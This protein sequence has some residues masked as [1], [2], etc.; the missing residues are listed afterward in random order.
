MTPNCRTCNGQIFFGTADVTECYKCRAVTQ[1]RSRTGGSTPLAPHATL[2]PAQTPS[3]LAKASPHAPSVAGPLEVRRNLFPESASPRL[4]Q[5]GPS[6]PAAPVLFPESASPTP[7][8]HV[9][10]ADPGSESEEEPEAREVV[11]I[12]RATP[13][14]STSAG[15]SPFGGGGPAPRPT[16][17]PTTS[18]FG[19]GSE[20][21]VEARQP[22]ASPFGGGSDLATE[23]RRPAGSHFAPSSAFSGAAVA[24]RH[25]SSMRGISS[26]AGEE[27]PNGEVEPLE[28]A[29]AAGE[30]PEKEAIPDAALE[31]AVPEGADGQEPTVPEGAADV[32]GEGDD[33]SPDSAT[34]DATIAEVIDV[35]IGEALDRRLPHTISVSVGGE[36]SVKHGGKV[37]V[38]HEGGHPPEA[39]PSISEPQVVEAATQLWPEPPT[40]ETP[41]EEA[42]P[43]LWPEPETYD[44]ESH[45]PEPEAYGHPAEP[46]YTEDEWFY[47]D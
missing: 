39:R 22:T 19:G 11:E 3:P 34:A 18:P 8:P 30:T 12:L 43:H 25:L 41:V 26:A 47:G 16:Q 27:L 7:C 31:A 40:H 15:W 46:G 14:A 6:F 1:A 38:A 35:A 33:D 2:S 28:T 13:A 21:P 20:L 9:R 36:F 37:R 4:Q 32:D 10:I 29:A 5:G 42:V 45:E 24:T 23:A 44:Q 17:Q